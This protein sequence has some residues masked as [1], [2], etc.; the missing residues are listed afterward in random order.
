MPLMKT[1]PS[2]F[3]FQGQGLAQPLPPSE[4]DPWTYPWSGAT[5][6][7]FPYPPPDWPR[8]TWPIVPMPGRP[9]TFPFPSQ[10]PQAQ[11]VSR[12]LS[13]LM[14]FLSGARGDQ[15]ENPEATPNSPYGARTGQCSKCRNR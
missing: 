13:A 10:A 6:P 7:G 4:P 15:E 1:A 8:F 3:G 12:T 14:A 2:P 9:P 5:I 11:G